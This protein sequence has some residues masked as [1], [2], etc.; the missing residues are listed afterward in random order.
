L[1]SNDWYPTFNRPNVEL[2]T[3]PISHVTADAVVTADGGE[4][5]L[6]TLIL[7]TGFRTTAFLAAIDVVGRHGVRIDD[8]WA[9]GSHAYL[10]M[11]TAGFPNLFM[12]YGPNT[13]NGSIIYMLECQA[14][15]VVRAL[16]WMRKE[17]IDWIDVRPDVE[18]RFNEQ[19]QR[20]LERV[21][22]WASDGC[23]NYY[24]GASGHIETQ[25]PHSMSE[26]R[27]RTEVFRPDDF[28]TGHR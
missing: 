7:A 16:S 21:G 3:V 2:V 27:R 11:T 9:D 20:D 5:V 19:L 1:I 15:Y 14:D 6:D 28:V 26:Y 8:A 18:A 24:R 25:W 4:H 17:S 10:G 12:L 23:H 13:N 22:V